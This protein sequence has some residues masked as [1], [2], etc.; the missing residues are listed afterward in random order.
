MPIEYALIAE[1]TEVLAEEPASEKNL[2]NI[3]RLI[4]GRIPKHNH[5]RTYQEDRYNFHYK[6]SGTHV[7]LCVADRDYPMRIC[8]AFLD[9][10]EQRFLQGSRNLRG[11]IKERIAFYNDRKNDKVMRVQ[12][13]IDEVKG[14]MIKNIDSVLERGE[15][16][17]VLMEKSDDLSKNAHLFK[18]QGTQL[19]REMWWKNLKLQIIIALIIIFVIFVIVLIACGGFQ[20]EKCK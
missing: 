13:Q 18:K 7:F 12:G 17:D 10:A 3:A 2:A 1:G 4:L 15:K 19:K 8:F 11:M 6:Y 14:V 16:L 9:D 20:F 5:K